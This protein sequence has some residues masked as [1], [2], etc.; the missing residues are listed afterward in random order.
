MW[1]SGQFI[2]LMS[3]Y[4]CSVFHDGSENRADQG[5]YRT[6]TLVPCRSDCRAPERTILGILSTLV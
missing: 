5:Y 1:V 3:G 6:M 2:L 4:L